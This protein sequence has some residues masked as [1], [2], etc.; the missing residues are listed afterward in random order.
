MGT[1]AKSSAKRS[2]LWIIGLCVIPGSVT[3]M[4]SGVVWYY[5]PGALE[6]ALGMGAASVAGFAAVATWAVL[7]LQAGR[8]DA[9]ILDGGAQTYRALGWVCAISAVLLTV[10]LAP[11]AFRVLAR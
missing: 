6:L 5:H 4:L 8:R 10:K 2:Y 9:R 3:P 1:T 7:R 11:F